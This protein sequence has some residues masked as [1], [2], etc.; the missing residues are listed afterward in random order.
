[1]KQFRISYASVDGGITKICVGNVLSIDSSISCDCGRI[2]DN[3]N[4]GNWTKPQSV[5]TNV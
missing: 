3:L 5:A 2:I 1:M 4:F